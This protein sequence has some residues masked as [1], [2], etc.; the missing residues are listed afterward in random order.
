MA[1]TPCG[2]AACISERQ[3][4][5]ADERRVFTEAVSGK[6]SWFEPVKFLPYAPDGDAGREQCR[7]RVVGADEG[8]SHD[9]ELAPSKNG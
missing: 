1:P 8:A 4:A 5:G 6:D 7:L 9:A 2:T 3:D